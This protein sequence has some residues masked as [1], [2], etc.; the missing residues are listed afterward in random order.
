[1]WRHVIFGIHSRHSFLEFQA[2][3]PYQKLEAPESGSTLHQLGIMVASWSSLGCSS[4][5]YAEKQRVWSRRCRVQDLLRTIQSL[6]V[7]KIWIIG[8]R[9]C[10]QL[11]HVTAANQWPLVK[12]EFLATV[13]WKW[14]RQPLSCHLWKQVQCRKEFCSTCL[15]KESIPFV[16]SKPPLPPRSLR[17][18][19]A[20]VRSTSSAVFSIQ[21]LD[22]RILILIS[23]VLHCVCFKSTKSRTDSAFSLFG[24]EVGL[25]AF[26]LTMFAKCDALPKGDLFHLFV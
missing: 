5:S 24:L 4:I 6:I 21:E 10:S 2:S 18:L 25:P 20:A 23:V 15:S 7:S 14:V 19:R 1:M 11:W 17:S 3:A 13:S 12:I 26:Q 9:L 22:C 8:Y 16:K